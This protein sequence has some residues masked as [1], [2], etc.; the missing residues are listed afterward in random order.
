MSI[1]KKHIYL[2]QED[3][4][5]KSSITEAMNSLLKERKLLREGRKHYNKKRESSTMAEGN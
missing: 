3:R 2:E 4:T 5:G 1:E